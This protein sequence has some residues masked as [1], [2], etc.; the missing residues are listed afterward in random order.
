MGTPWY[1]SVFAQRKPS[2]PTLVVDLDGTIAGDEHEELDKN[3]PLPGCL[4]A[5]T[6]LKDAGYKIVVFTCRMTPGARPPY[7]MALQ[8]VAIEEW[9]AKHKIPYDELY[10]GL[11]GKPRAVAYLDNKSIRVTPDNWGDVA[12]QILRGI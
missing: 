10:D 2:Q 9:L 4:E 8:R 11:K 3:E 5:L 6:K 7:V 12:S 1:A